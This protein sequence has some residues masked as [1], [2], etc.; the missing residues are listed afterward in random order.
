FELLTLTQTG[1]SAPMPIVLYGKSFWNK[2]VNF[3]ALVDEGLISAGDLKQFA[4]VDSVEE[5]FRIVSKG[6]GRSHSER[7]RAEENSSETI[8]KR[9]EEPGKAALRRRKKR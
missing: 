6:L 1:K 2:V 9:D 4:I 8:V 3:Q 7:A 5:A